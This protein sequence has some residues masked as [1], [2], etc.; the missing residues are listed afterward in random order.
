[1]AITRSDQVSEK[2]KKSLEFGQFL[3]FWGSFHLR[4]KASTI[5]FDNFL[6]VFRPSGK[7]WDI[8]EKVALLLNNH[9]KLPNFFFSETRS[10][11]VI[12]S[13][14]WKSL[15]HEQRGHLPSFGRVALTCFRLFC[16]MVDAL[17]LTAGGERLQDRG[18]WGWVSIVE[19]IRHC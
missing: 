12:A 11:R 13:W 1:M 19:K 6:W 17:V 8:S 18:V 15:G 5:A 14:V 10:G 9:P 3:P 7:E 2:K 4:N 16:R